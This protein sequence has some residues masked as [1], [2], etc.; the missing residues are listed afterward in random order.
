[1]ESET[2]VPAPFH[3]SILCDERLHGLRLDRW[4]CVPVDSGFAASAISLYLESEHPLFGFFDPDLFLT[5][6][7]A[8]RSR[9]CSPLLVSSVMHR[10]CVSRSNILRAFTD[11]EAANV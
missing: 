7:L 2:F 4:S 10:A 11:I 8:G 1:M 6:L 9:F 3:A 5:D